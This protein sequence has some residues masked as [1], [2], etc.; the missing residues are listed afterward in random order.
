MVTDLE[1]EETIEGRPGSV[2]RLLKHSAGLRP[3]SAKH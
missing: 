1:R 3:A 2:G